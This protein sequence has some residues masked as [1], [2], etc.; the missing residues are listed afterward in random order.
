MRRIFPIFVIVI[1]LLTAA[2]YSV[3]VTSCNPITKPDTTNNNNGTVISG[4]V[5][6]LN[7]YPFPGVKVYA[8]PTNFTTTLPDG[9][10]S[11]ANISYPVSLVVKKD[12]DSTINIYQNL[13]A[14]NPNLTYNSY[15]EN[16]SFNE[17]EF[18]IHY[19]A[20]TSDK[21]ML[22]QFATEDIITFSYNYSISDTVSARVPIKWEGNKQTLFGKLILIPYKRNPFSPFLISSYEGYAEKTFYIDTNR[23]IN[24]TFTA[25]DFTTNPSEG[26]IS[27]RN[28]GFGI[29]VDNN[30]YFSLSGNTNS[31]MLL[32][33][34][35][36]SGNFDFVVPNIFTVNRMRLI[37]RRP[38]SVSNEDNYVINNAYTPENSIV[39]FNPIPEIALLEPPLNSTTVDSTTLFKVTGN[40]S[41]PGVY[42]YNYTIDGNFFYS[43]WIYNASAEFTY[44]DLS[45]Y[46]LFNLRKGTNYKWSV[47]KVTPFGNLDDYCSAPVNKILKNYDIQSNS[48]RFM[49]KA[50]TVVIPS[51]VLKKRK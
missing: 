6:D 7:G 17:G 45:G 24:T 21:S 43:V 16:T 18:F 27:V 13:N 50:D 28:N 22:I 46:G 30:I 34:Y 31:D 36:F 39:T 41:T 42:L 49:T 9:F 8:S 33:H 48:S 15:S 29:S 44:P 37:S 12:G 26:I 35:S 10:F 23:I 11:L 38:Y 14:N 40:T 32:E 4:K 5:F 20:L 25:D 51:P 19:P 3:T 2:F 1:L 47:Q